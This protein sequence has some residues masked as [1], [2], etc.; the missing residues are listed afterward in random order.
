MFEVGICMLFVM[1]RAVL[2]AVGV[3]ECMRSVCVCLNN[4]VRFVY[5]LLCGVVCL[6]GF[7]KCCVCWNVS[8]C[9]VSDL[10]CGAVWCVCCLCL[11]V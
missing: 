7:V 6:F 11:S 8:V 3:V 2:S 1:D 10:F 9:F 5:A 4:C